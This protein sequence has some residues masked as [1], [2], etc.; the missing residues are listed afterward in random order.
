VIDADAD[1]VWTALLETVDTTFPAPVAR[2][3]GCDPAAR[4]GARPLAAGATIVGFRV[5]TADAPHALVLA[6][7]HRFST[8]ALTFR[9]EPVTPTRTRLRAETRASFPGM[10]G[11]LYRAL[12]IG[13]RGHRVAV[14]RMLAAIAGRARR[15]AVTASAG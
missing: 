7:R 1:A 11:G 8:Y 2:V 14:G 9:L 3:L 12:V 13:S 10:S 6:G 4:S 15:A 5:E